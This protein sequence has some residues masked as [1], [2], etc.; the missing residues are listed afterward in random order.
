MKPK[1]IA[2]I[3]KS[4]L[5]LLLILTSGFS[6]LYGRN[7]TESIDSAQ[8]FEEAKQVINKVNSDYLVAIRNGDFKTIAEPY[9]ENGIFVGTS[10]EIIV[11]AKKIEEYYATAAKVFATLTDIQLVQEGITMVGKCVYEWGRVDFYRG[12]KDQNSSKRSGRYVTVW[13]KDKSSQWRII[14][15][16]ALP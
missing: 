4:I 7:F 10:G 15:N 3:K 1:P 9:G 5:P 16:L 12:G 13:A 6:S 11:G 8:L 14:R 2:R